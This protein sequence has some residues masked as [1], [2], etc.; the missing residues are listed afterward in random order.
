MVTN[1]SAFV[2]RLSSHRML[3][4]RACKKPPIGMSRGS[5]HIRSAVYSKS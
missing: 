5:S 1:P 2:G 3:P 4:L